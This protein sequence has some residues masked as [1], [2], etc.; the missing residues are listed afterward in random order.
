VRIVEQADPIKGGG[1]AEQVQRRE[2]P[3]IDSFGHLVHHRNHGHAEDDHG[4]KHHA[5]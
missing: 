1:E 3:H 2:Q 5:G 4:Q